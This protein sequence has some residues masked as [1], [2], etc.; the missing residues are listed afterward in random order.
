MDI[1]NQIESLPAPFEE[2]LSQWQAHKHLAVPP[3]APIM[4][5]HN[6]GCHVFI[7][8][9]WGPAIPYPPIDHRDGHQNHGYEELKGNVEA[10]SL[11]PEVEGWP[12]LE[13]FLITINVADSPLE[14]AGCEK[15][16][17][18]AEIEGKPAANLGSYIDVIFTN[19]ALNDKA[20]NLLLLA[21]HLAQAVKGCEKWWGCVELS[22]HRFRRVPGAELPWGL[23]IRVNNHG[24][25]EEEARKFWGE[26]LRRLSDAIATLPRDLQWTE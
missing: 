11:I 4:L 17:F 1:P 7:D 5:W 14:S 15:H 16:Y 8:N 13:Q 22:L 19:A 10:V 3:P 6:E 23:M 24:R 25:T 2:L 26:T 9:E 12:E 20:E 18:P 21:S